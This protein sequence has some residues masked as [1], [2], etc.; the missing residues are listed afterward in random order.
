MAQPADGTY[1]VI[2]ANSLLALD[3][4]GASDASGTNVQ[5]YTPNGSDAQIWAL[6]EHSNGSQLICSL[7]GKALDLANGTVDDGTNIRQWSDN[8]SLAQRWNLVADGSTVTYGGETYDTYLIETAKDSGYVAAVSGSS[9]SAGANVLLWS[10]TGSGGQ[11]WAFVPVPAL[12][13][14]GTYEL[15][16]AVAEGVRVDISGGSTANGANAQIWSAN[17]GD[18]QRFE[19]GV[20][21][22]TGLCTLANV[23]SGKLLAVAGSGTA[24]GTN[25]LQWSPTGSSGQKWLPV[26]DGTME[27]NGNAVPTY[28]IRAQVGTNLAM[29]VCGGSSA[30]KTNVQVWTRNGSAAQRFHLMKTERLAKDLPAPTKLEPALAHGTGTVTLSC[31]FECDATAFQARMRRTAHAADGT[32]AAG[33]WQNLVDGSTAREGWGDAWAPTFVAQS[34]GTVALPVTLSEALDTSTPRVDYEVEVRA[35]SASYGATG[36]RAHGPTTSTTVSLVLDPTIT[37]GTVTLALGDVPALLVPLSSNVALDGNRVSVTMLSQASS[38]IGERVSATVARSGSVAVPVTSMWQLPG[39]GDTVKAA[40]EWETPDG[41][42]YSGTLTTTCSMGSSPVTAT[43]TDGPNMTDVLTVPSASAR[44]WL[45]VPRGDGTELAEV[46]GEAGT[47]SSTFWAAPPLNVPYTYYVATPAGVGTVSVSNAKAAGGCWWVWGERWANAAH[48]EAQVGGLPSQAMAHAP[49]AYVL[50]TTGRARPIASA[51]RSVAVD[52]SVTG[53]V[54]PSSG[55]SQASFEALAAALGRGMV[56]V[57]R[58]VRGDWHRVAVTGVDLGWGGRDG[59]S[60]KVSQ[61]AVSP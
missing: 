22:E 10:K 58:S 54:G 42:T 38:P 51:G 33:G 56:P 20:D 19:A 39:N 11:R 43:V 9:P 18:A 60:V 57:F 4:R 53:W 23:K 41:G 50:R 12:T 49:A 1:L 6:V 7:T 52:L 37:A 35:F 16:P 26:L 59:N 17:G 21:A 61:E 34:G 3:V 55:S 48:V 5:Q 14:G 47:S 30:L 27:V 28:Q 25:V 45:A 40:V 15:V 46:P 32:L 36:S 13:E 2:N 29:D 31:A 8:N 24:P 44:A